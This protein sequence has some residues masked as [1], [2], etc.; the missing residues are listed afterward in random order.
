VAALGEIFVRH[1]LFSRQSSE[2]RGFQG[3]RKG[4][5]LSGGA[6]GPDLFMVGFEDEFAEGQT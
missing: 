4:G 5:A 1:D 3:K 2:R 6:F